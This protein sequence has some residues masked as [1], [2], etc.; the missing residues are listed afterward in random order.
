MF[1]YWLNRI[2]IGDT[3]FGIAIWVSCTI[4]Y[5][6]SNAA[7]RWPSIV[8][9]LYFF[10]LSFLLMVIAHYI[11]DALQIFWVTPLGEPMHIVK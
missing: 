10:V 11:I 3:L 2:I 4:A 8:R 5:V 7:R 9:G 6:L 1:F